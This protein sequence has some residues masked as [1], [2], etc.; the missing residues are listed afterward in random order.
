MTRLLLTNV[1]LLDGE[2]TAA[3]GSTVVLEGDRISDVR[4][5]PGGDSPA[6]SEGDTVIDMEGRTVMP[7]MVIGH[8][9]G[10]YVEV[11]STMA[12]FGLENPVGYTAMVAAR[13]LETALSCGFTGLV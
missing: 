11:G 3:P 2:H 4:V 10:A 8:F 6:P 1:N 7:G 13:N 9:H 12:P 5:G